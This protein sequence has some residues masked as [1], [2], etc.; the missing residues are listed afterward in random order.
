[1]PNINHFLGFLEGGRVSARGGMGDKSP[2]NDSDIPS[3]LIFW[4]KI[5][6]GFE[7]LIL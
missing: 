1:M 5:F 7:N 4:G 6:S 2:S 3:T